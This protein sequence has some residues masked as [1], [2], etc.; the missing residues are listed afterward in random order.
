L[1][2]DFTSASTKLMTV[3]SSIKI[4][5]QWYLNNKTWSRKRHKCPWYIFKVFY[6]KK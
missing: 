6:V 3:D 4:I 1:Y 5:W 2:Q